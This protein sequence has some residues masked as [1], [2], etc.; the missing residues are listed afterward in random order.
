[1]DMSYQHNQQSGLTSETSSVTDAD[2]Q[3]LTVQA[4]CKRKNRKKPLKDSTSSSSSSIT[5]ESKSRSIP[6]RMRNNS[7]ASVDQGY[8][9]ASPCTT[10]VIG[11]VVSPSNV[12]KTSKHFNKVVTRSQ[13]IP[14]PSS[15]SS[16][17]LFTGFDIVKNNCHHATPPLG[18][19]FTTDML[20]NDPFDEQQHQQ[21]DAVGRSSLFP[22]SPL[23]D[24]WKKKQQPQHSL[25]LP[26]VEGKEM[27]F[28]KAWRT[29]QQQMKM[30][31]ADV[32]QQNGIHTET[33]IVPMRST[34][35]AKRVDFSV[36]QNVLS[37]QN[38]N[39]YR[40]KMEGEGYGSDDLR[41]MILAALSMARCSQMNCVLCGVDLPIYH[42]FP[43]IDGTMFLSP[44][45]NESGTKN[46]FKVKMEGKCEYIHAACLRCLEGFHNIVCRMCDTRWEGTQHQLGTLY[47]YDIFAANPCCQNR[48][49]CKQCGVALLDIR[50]GGLKHFSDYSSKQ[51]CPRCYSVDYHF[52][53]PI[54]TYQ[55][56]GLVFS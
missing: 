2:I 40:I 5:A 4:K 31:G 33:R 22:Y 45:R 26:L 14:S 34:T 6:A 53:K 51:T 43:L 28:A 13:R 18:T 20:N 24:I 3:K 35:F 49:C 17:L 32:G 21:Q 56:V 37:K 15:S 48:L 23:D 46:P 9:S 12:T 1:M 8:I 50:C 27:H 39:P 47:T 19:G 11:N 55:L 52:V 25:S 38:I 36:F 10:D 54:S 42:H 7:N 16:S 41:N 30:M 44:L 29:T